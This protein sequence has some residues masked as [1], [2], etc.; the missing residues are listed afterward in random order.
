MLSFAM[1]I[2]KKQDG[3]GEGE[4]GREKTLVLLQPDCE[5]AS[6]IQIEQ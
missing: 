6:S 3:E 2:I 4:K 5:N 1:L